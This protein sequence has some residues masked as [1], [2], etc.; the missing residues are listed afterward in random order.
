MGIFMTDEKKVPRLRS[1]KLLV[2]ERDLV[3]FKFLDRVGYA[4][5][6]QVTRAVGLD[7][8]EKAQQAII[9]RLYL[10]RRFE[11][12]KVFSTQ[13]GNYYALTNKS[14][15][16]NALIS[17]IKLDQLQHHDF[18]TELF[19]VVQ[20]QVLLS[21]RECISQYKVVGKK[22]KVPDMV[23]NDWIIEYERTNKS[24]ADCKAVVDYWTSE[25]AQNLCVVYEIDEIKNRYSALL[26]PRVKLLASSEYANIMALLGGAKLDKGSDEQ[27]SSGAEYV[28]NIVNKYR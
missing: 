20:S 19:F 11:Y 24:V 14:K 28:E 1:E 13:K 12:L 25:K 23:I 16:D 8:G 21:E 17:T 26:N 27:G 4:N 9:R 15:I 6:E 7:G 10:L 2:Q 22:G 18:L 3:I 5:L